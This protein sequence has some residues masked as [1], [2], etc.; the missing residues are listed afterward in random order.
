VPFERI[1][2]ITSADIALRITGET[3]GELFVA[4]G[5]ALCAVML[6]E[7]GRAADSPE[8]MFDLDA[9]SIEALLYS[10]L[11]G[12]LF[13]KD[14]EALL[15][16]PAAVEVRH[17]A[18]GASLK[19]RAFSERIDP[20]VHRFIVDIKAVTMHRFSVRFENGLWTATVVLDV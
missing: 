1:E 7:N 20:S 13:Y 4:A 9:E 16:R 2:N 8:I 11:D 17:D 18:G 5:A 6:E 12:L 3:P 19:C 10:F 15:V 14:S